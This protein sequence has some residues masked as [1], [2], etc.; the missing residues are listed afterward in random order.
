MQKLLH[1]S[2]GAIA[3]AAIALVATTPMPF[4]SGAAAS[5]PSG[6]GQTYHELQLFGRAFDLVRQDYVEKPEAKKLI[7]SR[8]QRHGER[9]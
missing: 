2:L 5:P 6:A 8:D 7:G 9:T 4:L 3:G 1:L